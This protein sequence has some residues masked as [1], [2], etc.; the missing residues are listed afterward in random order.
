MPQGRATIDHCHVAIIQSARGG[1]E[2]VSD[3]AC[4][5]S[6]I[7]EGGILFISLA[8]LDSEHRVLDGNGRG[9]GGEDCLADCDI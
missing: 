2:H 5:Y 7:R 3:A 8:F 1:L 9:E 4:E 6:R